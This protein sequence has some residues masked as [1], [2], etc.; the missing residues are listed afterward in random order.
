MQACPDHLHQVAHVLRLQTHAYISTTSTSS[1]ALG[2][3]KDL[4]ETAAHLQQEGDPGLPVE[5]QLISSQ[6]LQDV[7]VA[8]EVVAGSGYV[9]ESGTVPAPPAQAGAGGRAEVCRA[10]VPLTAAAEDHVLLQLGG[11]LGNLR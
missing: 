4:S 7:F 9:V 6:P 8:G 5:L 2:L 1:K 11:T 10:Q 3:K